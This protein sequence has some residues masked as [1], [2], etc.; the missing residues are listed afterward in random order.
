LAEYVGRP[1]KMLR[2]R[3]TLL[4]GASLGVR[5]ETCENVARAVELVH[6]ASLLHDDCVDEALTRRG[7]PTPNARF[8]DRTGILLGD[9]AFTE[10]MA[11]A[12]KVSPRAVADLVA[13]VGEMTIGEIQEEYLCGSLNVSA[14]GYY[15]V[16]VRKTA[17]LFDW[18]GR[19]LAEQSELKHASGDPAR[20]GRSAGILLQIIDDIHDYTLDK[21]TAGKD[22]GQDFANGRLTLPAIIAMDDEDTRKEFLPMWQARSKDPD[23]FGR[24]L[25]LLKD[26]GHLDAAKNKAREIMEDMLPIV[27]RLPV[28]E[29]AA[30]LRMYME[31]LFRREF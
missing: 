3:Y 23:A 17:A 28:K 30:E 27:D 9:L 2:A 25:S 8:G 15:G 26:R 19:T 29:S 21:D 13:A 20:L 14:E 10:G 7:V 18:A 16:A 5:P 4:L 6:N 1:G 31:L 11:E 22:P 24:V 12:V